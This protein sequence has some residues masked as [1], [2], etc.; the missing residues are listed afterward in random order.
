MSNF[1]AFYEHNRDRSTGGGGGW[2]QLELTDAL[3]PLLPIWTHSYVNTRSVAL[4]GLE[5]GF[6]NLL[7]INDLFLDSHIIFVIQHPVIPR[8][9]R[10][11]NLSRGVRARI[12]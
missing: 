6:H 9:A 10:F 2:A 8:E 11:I 7:L 4:I 12:A 5:S 1:P 3:G